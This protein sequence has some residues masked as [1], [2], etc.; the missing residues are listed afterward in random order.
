MRNDKSETKSEKIVFGMGCFWCAE[1]VFSLVPGVKAV[2]SGYAGGELKDPTYE[3][4][5]TGNTGHV[6]VVS[7][8][9]DPRVVSLD[10]LLEIF[11]TAHDPT[12]LNRQGSDVGTQYRSVILCGSNAQLSAVQKFKEQLEI[13]GR[14]SKPI[15]TEIKLLEN[16]YRAEDYHQQYFAKHPSQA[17]CQAVIR[18]KVEKVKLKI[19]GLIDSS[20]IID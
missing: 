5:C 6:E 20:I 7:L 18:P 12:S 17:Y 19:P 1:A 4:V 10:K 14:F 3:A 9:Y 15:V 8:E 2:V 11:F 13:K 16:F